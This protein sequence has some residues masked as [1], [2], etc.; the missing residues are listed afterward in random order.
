MKGLYEAKQVKDKQ[1]E[2][3]MYKVNTLNDIK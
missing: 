1:P 2:N 3:I